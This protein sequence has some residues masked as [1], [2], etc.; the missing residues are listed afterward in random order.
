MQRV[1]TGKELC[2]MTARAKM[3]LRKTTDGPSR[4]HVQSTIPGPGLQCTTHTVHRAAT[5]APLPPCPLPL[6]SPYPSRYSRAHSRQTG[7]NER[8]HRKHRAHD[9]QYSYARRPLL[10][11]VLSYHGAPVSA[12]VRSGRT[13]VRV[14]HTMSQVDVLP[15]HAAPGTNDRN[16]RLSSPLTLVR[17][18][19]PRIITVIF[20][21]CNG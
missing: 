10:T 11:Y 12:Q 14:T 21:R 4:R 7:E 5:P 16:C 18:D 2:K 8:L 1:P 9:L 13:R 15:R 20:A 17:A 6:V 19:R 3:Y